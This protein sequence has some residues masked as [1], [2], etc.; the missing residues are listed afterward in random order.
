MV[1]DVTVPLHMIN[2]GWFKHNFIIIYK[3][4]F[5]NYKKNK[6][7]KREINSIIV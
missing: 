5:I 2:D 7:S 1:A 6:K 3:F 4:N